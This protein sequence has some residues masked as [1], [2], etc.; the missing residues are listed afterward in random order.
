MKII[1]RLI[2]KYGYVGSKRVLELV[3]QE[4]EL[5]NNLSVAAH[6]IHGSSEGRFKITY[7]PIKLNEKEIRQVN[8]NYLP[9]AEA[10]KQYDPSSLQS[11]FNTL[12]NGERI[13]FISNPALGL[14]ALTEKF[15]TQQ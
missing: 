13:F 8:Y 10:I 7:A 1:D 2:Q 4:E 14:W 5:R 11:G 3:K 15:N 12:P 9:F 6:L